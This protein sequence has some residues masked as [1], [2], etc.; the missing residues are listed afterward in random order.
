[1]KQLLLNIQDLLATVPAFK[2]V[3]EDWG[4]LD[5]YGPHAPVQWPCCLIDFSGADYSD[6]GKDKGAT[7]QN[8]QEATGSI[9]FTFANLKLTK[10]SGKAPIGQKDAAWLL[11][12]L[13]EDA[14]KQL[15]GFR[16]ADYSGALMR[17]SF[18]RIKRDDGIQQYQVIYT[19][20]LHNV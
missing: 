9:S 5:D 6:L 8:R 3:D 18:R 2:Y 12:G 11:V 20:G 13:I 14:H 19:L 15:H 10:S 4:Q 17:R 7:P 1:M 16:P